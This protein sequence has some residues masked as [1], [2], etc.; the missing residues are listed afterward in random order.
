MA[1]FL[2]AVHCCTVSARPG[3]REVA[4]ERQP[5]SV[6]RDLNHHKLPHYAGVFMFQDV[7]VEHV[8][9]IRVGEVTKMG[10]KSDSFARHAPGKQTA[11]FAA[12]ANPT[13]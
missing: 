8:R 13:T 10:D 3:A 4:G 6:G 7:A 1:S 5:Y 12:S 2:G 11:T 9:F